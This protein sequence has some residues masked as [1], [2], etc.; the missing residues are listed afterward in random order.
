MFIY[1]RRH[2]NHIILTPTSMSLRGYSSSAFY[3]HRTRTSTMF[4]RAGSRCFL[5]KLYCSPPNFHTLLC[6]SFHNHVLPRVILPSLTMGKIHRFF[7]E[8]LCELYLLLRRV[9]N[10]IKSTRVFQ[11]YLFGHC[12]HMPLTN[13]F[14][15]LFVSESVSALKNLIL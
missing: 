13:T 5:L 4:S 15:F 1:I 2:H 8:F 6:K 11:K 9:I 7:F 10:A 3:T 12:L 14:T